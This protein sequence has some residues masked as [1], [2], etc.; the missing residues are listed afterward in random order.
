[1]AINLRDVVVVGAGPAGLSAASS[2]RSLGI[3]C[4]VVEAGPPVPQRDQQNQD[5]VVQGVGGAGLFSDGKFSFWPS[6]TQLWQ[7]DTELL[8]PAWDETALFLQR[9]DVETHPYASAPSEP[10]TP[11]TIF[12]KRYHSAYAG[13]ATRMRLIESL[14]EGLDVETSSRVSAI[15]RSGDRWLVSLDEREILCGAVVV[16]SGRFGPELLDR[17]DTVAMIPRRLEAGVRI[18]QPA[19][20]F[21]LGDHPQLDPKYIWTETDV[22]W[23]TFCC[24]RDGLVVSTRAAGI[25]SVSG[26]AD[27]PPTGRSN[28]GFNVR[29]TNPSRIAEVWPSLR[30]RLQ[31]QTAPVRIPWSRF[32]QMPHQNPIGDLLGEELTAWLQRGLEELLRHFGPDALRDAQLVGPT[33]EGVGMYPVHNSRLG[34]TAPGLWVAGDV[35]GTFRGLVAALVSGGVAGHAIGVWL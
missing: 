8:Q 18:E 13:V 22:E 33:L 29:L 4:L 10:Q 15:R 6:A 30:E 32:Q 7:L 12:E 24:C 2:L 23:R 28:I 17:V 14:Q 21:F 34:T 35:A 19:A 31:T 25:F 16:A 20:S 9:H 1:M 3:G 26:R 5:T 11:S 27:C